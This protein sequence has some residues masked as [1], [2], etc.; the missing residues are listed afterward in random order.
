MTPPTFNPHTSAVQ[1][2][3]DQTPV[4]LLG[5]KDGTAPVFKTGEFTVDVATNVVNTDNDLEENDAIQLGTTGILPTNLSKGRLYYVR[6]V[7][8]TGFVVSHTPGGAVVDILGE[9]SGTHTWVRA[10]GLDATLRPLVIRR[11]SGGRRL[12]HVDFEFDLAAAGERVQ[13]ARTPTGFARQV[14]VRLLDEKGLPTIPL[15]WGDVT[16]QTLQLGRTTGDERVSVRAEVRPYH[17]GSVLEGFRVWDPINEEEVLVDRD[18][19]FNPEIEG[20]IVGNRSG[21]G[22]DDDGEVVTN[23]ATENEIRLH[24]DPQSIRTAS[25]ETVQ[26]EGNARWTLEDAVR[27]ICVT[28]NPDETFVRNPKLEG[29]DFEFAPDPKNIT[30]RR[31]QYLPAYLDALLPPHGLD[32]SL[33]YEIEE[34]E[35]VRTIVVHRRDGVDSVEKSLHWL[36][37]GEDFTST[38]DQ[39]L[40][41]VRLVQNVGDVANRVVGQGAS[42]QREVTLELYRGWS[43]DDDEATDLDDKP[44]V[45]RRWPANLAGDYCYESDGSTRLR[46]TTKPIPTTPPDLSAVFDDWAPRERRWDRPLTIDEDGQR[47]RR[48]FLEYSTDDGATWIDFE[49]PDTP[50][51]VPYRVLHDEATLEFSQVPALLQA[52]GDSARV[53][54]TGV[55]TGDSR[56][57]KTAEAGD[58]TPNAR[59]VT[60]FL[61]LSDRFAD[62][63]VYD[64]SAFVKHDASGVQSAFGSVLFDAVGVA[65]EQDDGDDLQNFVDDVRDNEQSARLTANLAMI[66]L[67]TGL[68]IGDV[69]TG[70]DGRDLDFNR[71]SKDAETERYLQVTGLEWRVEA[72]TTLPTVTPTE[73]LL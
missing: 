13:A 4:V 16:E 51:G 28:C 34:G 2:A 35:D 60:L 64:A 63:Q 56:V 15:A 11:S 54:C 58:N 52:A 12:D 47:Y 65:D 66:G 67:V 42:Q 59:D 23:E 55:L 32:W 17:F 70:V 8:N 21:R 18:P 20:K 31:G 7:D 22:F 62:R 9:G 46:G 25:A 43:E 41:A 1:F 14:S 44:H 61:N 40:E 68:E 6:N 45:W 53:R 36:A 10:G 30:L 50:L 38:A 39:D 48:L 49:D 71:N 26:G 33:R 5:P 37:V 3:A 72:R 27:W 24:V 69:V 29:I 19:T 73:A 57:Q